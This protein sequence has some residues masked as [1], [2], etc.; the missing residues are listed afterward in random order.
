MLCYIVNTKLNLYL[1]RSV[2]AVH[3]YIFAVFYDIILSQVIL[4]IS[5]RK[6]LKITFNQVI[7]VHSVSCVP[8]D[9]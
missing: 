2:P 4:A 6:P 3:I 7:W 9:W 1:S 5:S 8:A